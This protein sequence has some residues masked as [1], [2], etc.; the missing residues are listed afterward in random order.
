MN[1]YVIAGA[2]IAVLAVVAA[3]YFKGDEAG[4]ATVRADVNA[5]TVQT[6]DEARKSKEQTDEDVART[7]YGDRVDGL[8]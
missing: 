4:S 3:I 8:R 6:L 2:I 5:Q 1:P 7:P